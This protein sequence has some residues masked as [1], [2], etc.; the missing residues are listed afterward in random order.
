MGPGGGSEHLMLI[1]LR[2]VGRGPAGKSTHSLRRSFRSVPAELS[3]GFDRTGS[4]KLKL[5]SGVRIGVL[6]LGLEL[7]C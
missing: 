2:S 4:N 3:L 5:S 7:G 1:D 6:E